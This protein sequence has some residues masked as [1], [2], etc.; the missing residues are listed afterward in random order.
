[1]NPDSLI[2]DDIGCWR[3]KELR[4]PVEQ[5]KSKEDQKDLPKA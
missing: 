2:G 5:R 4:I 3:S 1:M